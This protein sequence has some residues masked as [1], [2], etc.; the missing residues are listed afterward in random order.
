MGKFILGAAIGS[1][2]VVLV[3]G[4]LFASLFP[5]YDT[6][7]L[8]GLDEPPCERTT[9]WDA[10]TRPW[11]SWD[12][13]HFLDLAERGWR[14]EKSA[15]FMGAFPA[16]ISWVA[17]WLLIP[18]VGE[19]HMC[20]RTLYRLAGVLFTNVCFVVAV[21]AFYA[22]SRAV[23]K[24]ETVARRAALLMCCSPANVFFSA[25]YTESPFAA[26]SMLALY[27]L[28]SNHGWAAALAFA[29]ATAFRSNGILHALI[30]VLMYGIRISSLMQCGFIVAPLGAH[31]V[32][33]YLHYCP[34][35][36]WCQDTLP[37][38]YAYVQAHYWNNGLFRYWTPNNVPNFMLAAPMLVLTAYGSR[39]IW[40]EAGT[41]CRRQSDILLVRA[42]TFLWGFMALL[43]LFTMN[44]QVVTRFLS[45]LPPLYWYV[46]TA[47]QRRYEGTIALAYFAVY[48]IVGIGLFTTFLP[49][50]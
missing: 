11:A 36:V 31:L 25:I 15:A 23:L 49:W 14:L 3:F 47:T 12:A 26:A 45:A 13:V 9:R 18:V 29:A 40:K 5:A 1:R 10:L 50:T 20:Q 44:V 43:A 46:A 17:R 2:I 28:V 39:S 21:M 37:N 38:A 16:C 35:H 41:M 6:S 32:W 33:C 34:G 8:M 42:L 7:V 19:Q 48:S 27:L 4:V 30:V 22:L 24:S